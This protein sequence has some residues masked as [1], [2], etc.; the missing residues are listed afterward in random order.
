MNIAVFHF[1]KGGCIQRIKLLDNIITVWLPF[2][3]LTIDAIFVVLGILYEFKIFTFI[4]DNA[5]N[6]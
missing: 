6:A 2:F 4:V 3:S 1:R 5:D